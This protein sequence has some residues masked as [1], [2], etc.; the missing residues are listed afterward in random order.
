MDS[1]LYFHPL[2]TTPPGILIEQGR[3]FER[4]PPKK[5]AAIIIEPLWSA[6]LF[7]EWYSFFSI[8]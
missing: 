3:H 7:R 1:G 8:P 2:E 5:T 4:P 6:Y